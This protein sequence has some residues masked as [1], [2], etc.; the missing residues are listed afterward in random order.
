MRTISL[1][2]TLFVI[3]WLSM[4]IILG[5]MAWVDGVHE[6][7]CH[8]LCKWQIKKVFTA[9]TAVQ[10]SK[11]FLLHFQELNY[12]HNISTLS[13]KRRT[14]ALSSALCLNHKLLTVYALA[15]LNHEL[16]TNSRLYNRR[17]K[18]SIQLLF[19]PSKHPM[20]ARCNGY[21][22]IVYI[23]LGVCTPN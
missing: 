6:I 11:Y 12:K 22:V 13:S 15:F 9:F 8:N 3:G 14:K 4:Q 23:A 10:S 16:S 1:Q 2:E 19:S 5:N 21:V 17:T 18:S 20:I 7:C